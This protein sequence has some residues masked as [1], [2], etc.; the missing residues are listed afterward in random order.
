M[1][2]LK[3]R[4]ELTRATRGFFESRGYLEVETP[5]AVGTPGEDTSM[6]STPIGWLRAHV[7]TDRNAWALRYASRASP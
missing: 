6:D 7:N 2:F 5:Y 4:G 1:P 3:R